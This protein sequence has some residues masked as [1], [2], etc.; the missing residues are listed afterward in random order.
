MENAS[1]AMLISGGVLVAML[2]LAIGV[3]LFANYSNIALSYEQK[4][5]T[6]EIQKFNANFIKFEGRKNITIHEIVTLANFAKQYEKQTGTHIKLDIQGKT[7]DLINWLNDF[8]TEEENKKI[9]EEVGLQKVLTLDMLN[10][11]HNGFTSIIYLSLLTL[12]FGIGIVL[13]LTI[14]I[15][16]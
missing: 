1:K 14:K 8:T 12:L 13:Y 7:N 4:I 3:Y 2:V 11:P 10:K 15:Y 9:K 5:E 6:I 16:M